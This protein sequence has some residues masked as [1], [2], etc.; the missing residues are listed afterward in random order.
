MYGVDAVVVLSLLMLH[1]RSDAAAVE[2]TLTW[3]LYL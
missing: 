3:E 2:G 1:E